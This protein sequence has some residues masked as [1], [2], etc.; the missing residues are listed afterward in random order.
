MISSPRPRKFLPLE[1]N[2]LQNSL[3]ISFT[4]SKTRAGSGADERAVARPA[5]IADR[6]AGHPAAEH[7]D[8]QNASLACQTAE[9]EPDSQR[10]APPLQGAAGADGNPS[11]GAADQSGRSTHP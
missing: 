2:P 6:E 5:A 8:H 10:G 3:E 9:E 7:P 1:R 11:S 4:A